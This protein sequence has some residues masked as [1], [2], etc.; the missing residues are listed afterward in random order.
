MHKVGLKMLKNKLSEYVRLAAAGDTV[1]IT[2]RDRIVAEIVPPQPRT[3]LTPFEE[4]GVGEGWLTP[5]RI[6]DGSPPPSKPVP[7]LTL[8]RLMSDLAR[9]REDR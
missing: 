1:V 2:D 7:G 8:E 6:R 4:K 3:G 5:A 9:D